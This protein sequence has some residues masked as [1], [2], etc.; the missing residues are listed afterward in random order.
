MIRF[1]KAGGPSLRISQLMVA[2]VTGLLQS[3]VDATPQRIGQTF[4]RRLYTRL[5][6]LDEVGSE[7][8]VGAAF[9]FTRIA[10]STEEWLDLD[11]WEDALRLN[12]SVQ[13]FSSQHGTLG[14]LYGDGSGSGTGGTVQI[15]THT[16]V[17]PRMEAW[18]GTWC[19]LVHSFTS[20]WKELRTLVHI[21]LKMKLKDTD[22]KLD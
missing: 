12:I 13:A 7:R 22:Y 5:H 14:I 6:L 16:G 1:L 18:M 11:W 19:P 4:L 15:L 2:V 9:Y 3:L 17:C 10:L 20:N 8:P 21:Y